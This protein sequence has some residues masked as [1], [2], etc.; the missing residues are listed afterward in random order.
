MNRLWTRDETKVVFHLS[1]R[2]VDFVSLKGLNQSTDLEEKMCK[3]TH[4]I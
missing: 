4:E 1:R 2:K 3:S